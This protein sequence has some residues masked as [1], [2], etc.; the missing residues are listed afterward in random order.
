MSR[1]KGR[2]V[3]GSVGC[4]SGLRGELMRSLFAAGMMNKTSEVMLLMSW[5]TFQLFE[6]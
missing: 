3:S 4:C 5:K 6:K 2:R 1:G